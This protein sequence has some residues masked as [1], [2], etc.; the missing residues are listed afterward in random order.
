MGLLDMTTLRFLFRYVAKSV[1]REKITIN[2]IIKM[3]L[4]RI[5]TLIPNNLNDYKIMKLLYNVPK[6]ISH[7]ESII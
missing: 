2:P 5:F 6:C 1:H 4:I 3:R 7:V